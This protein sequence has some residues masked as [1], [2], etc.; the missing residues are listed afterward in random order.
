MQGVFQFFYKDRYGIVGDVGMC[1][2][3]QIHNIS[4]STEVDAHAFVPCGAL[5]ISWNINERFSIGI[6]TA[7]VKGESE[8]LTSESLVKSSG[9]GITARIN[10]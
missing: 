4:L 5:G 9:T 7:R 6:K 8:T 1:Y 3:K 2:S 10:L